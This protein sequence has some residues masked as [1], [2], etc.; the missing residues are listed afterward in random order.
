MIQHSTHSMVFLAEQYISS[1]FSTELSDDLM[2][3]NLKHTLNVVRGVEEI[4]NHLGLSEKL[5][6]ILFLAAWFHDA[7]HVTTYERHEVES[8][9]LATAFLESHHYP[10]QKIAQVL[11]CIG[12]TRMPQRPIGLMEEIICDADLYHLSLQEYLHLQNLLRT[13]WNLVLNKKYS[14]KDWEKENL[15]FLKNHSY[16]TSYGQKVLQ[17]R[18]EDQILILS[19]IIH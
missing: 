15:F 12:A 13:E 6:E 8:Q 4:S 14:D 16:F 11:S 10:A 9:R 5:R 1:L 18:K 3:H 2:F 7:G 17:K 19:R